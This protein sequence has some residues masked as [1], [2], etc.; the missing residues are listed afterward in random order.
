KAALSILLSVWRIYWGMIRDS[1]MWAF[2]VIKAEVT[3]AVHIVMDV[4]AIFL[5]IVTGHW[6]KAWKDVKKLFHDAVS[7]IVNIARAWGSG[8]VRFFSDLGRNIVSGLINGIKSM[9][10][11]VGG[12]ISSLGGGIIGGIKSVLGIFSPSRAMHAIGALAGQGLADGL[13]S[14]TAAVT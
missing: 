13:A 6:S 2:N 5:D 12:V 11:A 4:I 9:F 10:G 7:G 14:M 8:F 1:V 3:M